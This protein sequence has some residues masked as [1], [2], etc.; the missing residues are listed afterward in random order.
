MCRLAQL[1]AC[2]HKRI[3]S[4]FYSSKYI[5]R[6][7]CCNLSFPRLLSAFLQHKC[8][9]QILLVSDLRLRRPWLTF[10]SSYILVIPTSRLSAYHNLYQPEYMY[11][12][13]PFLDLKLV[14]E[15]FEDETLLPAGCKGIRRE[16]GREEGGPCWSSNS[17]ELR[18]TVEKYSWK[19]ICKIRLRNTFENTVEKYIWEYR[20][21]IHLRIPLPYAVE[22]YSW[23]HV[24]KIQL[25]NTVVKLRGAQEGRWPLLVGRLPRVVAS[26]LLSLAAR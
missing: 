25:R 12:W 8:S 21:K 11:V 1:G 3:L 10:W 4:K 6:Q 19:H 24:C 26:S 22:K 7:K 9:F 23:K 20:W 5:L 17:Q 18:N 13:Q 14:I 15:V 2:P 16:G